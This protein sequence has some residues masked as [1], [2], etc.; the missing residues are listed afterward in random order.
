MTTTPLS[1]SSLTS[2]GFVNATALTALLLAALTSAAC[3][4]T[5]QAAPA[6]AAT[7]IAVTTA[8]ATTSALPATF[9]AGGIVRARLSAAVAS[10]VMA[11]VTDVRVHAGD[12]VRKGDPLVWLDAREMTA[13]RDRAAAAA[14]AAQESSAA[15]D[16][17]VAAAEA[18]LDLARATHQRIAALATKQSATPQELDQAVAGLRA[19]EAQ[20][21]AAQAR[22]A[23]AAAGEHAAAAATVAADT[24]LSYTRLVAPFDAMVSERSVDPGAMATPGLPLLVLEDVSSL[25]LEVRVD[26]ARASQLQVGQP[27]EVSAAAEGA[28]A[29]AG[30]TAARITELAR[31]DPASHSFVVKIDLPNDTTV[32]S[33]SFARARFSGAPR[34]ALTIPAAALVQRGQIAFV[35]VVDQGAMAR[36]RAV[37]S[38]A[39]A[40]G[41]VELLAGLA[42]GDVLVLNPPPA[43][44]D[45]HPVQAARLR[46]D[47]TTAGTGAGATTG[48][49]R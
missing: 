31:I 47:T 46:P 24:G 40:N 6:S 29:A 22:R 37:S 35:F 39:T 9:E 48:A 34:S 21:R 5:P 45:G 27:V 19:A 11:P 17:D 28:D 8:T 49:A 3:S 43:L 33:G 12:H 20:V 16:A 36:L 26:E 18:S 4:T 42:D 41:R 10:R 14:T 44:T 13:N 1:I 32:R 23:A 7:P 25:R 2:R 38:G 15:A 30:W